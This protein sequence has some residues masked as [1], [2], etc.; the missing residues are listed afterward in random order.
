MKNLLSYPVRFDAKMFR[1]LFLYALLIA[2]PSIIVA[3]A[4]GRPQT[5]L[6][7]DLNLLGSSFGV[8]G[9]NLSFTHVIV[10]AGT[11][12]LVL[13]T[14]LAQN[15]SNSVA[16]IEAGG[17]YEVDNGNLS[18]IPAF[19]IYDSGASPTDSNPLIDW[20][21]VTTPQAVSWT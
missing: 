5:T 13:A 16:V 6:G 2:L 17:F 4:G 8:P 21:F 15:A 12:G 18:V 20:G 1:I 14:R 9:R 7:G 10:G 19:A 11:A 3:I